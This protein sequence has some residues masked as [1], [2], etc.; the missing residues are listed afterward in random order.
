M[1]QSRVPGEPRALPANLQRSFRALGRA[2][3]K[4]DDL[5]VR[6]NAAKEERRTAMARILDE[7]EKNPHGFRHEVHR[8]GR[9]HDEPLTPETV[10]DFKRR[11]QEQ[12][13]RQE[14]PE[15]NPHGG[16]GCGDCEDIAECW[17]SFGAGPL[18]CY[19][20]FSWKV[21]RCFF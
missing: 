7:L 2:Q 11:M 9:V 20:C 16:P 18:C 1:A 4:L 8:E 17:C 21:I 5:T 10:R 13:I 15:P 14:K 12:A 6:R 19:V 3:K